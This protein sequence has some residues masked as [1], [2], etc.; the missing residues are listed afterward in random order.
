[1]NN[2]DLVKPTAFLDQVHTGVVLNASAN[3]TTVL[4]K[5]TGK[6]SSHEFPQEKRKCCQSLEEEMNKRH[7]F[8]TTWQDTDTNALKGT[9]NWQTETSSN[10]SRNHNT[11][12]VTKTKLLTVF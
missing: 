4:L 12:E 5:S 7:R 8:P 9:A 3:R 2:V 6:C 11:L 1:M 10:S